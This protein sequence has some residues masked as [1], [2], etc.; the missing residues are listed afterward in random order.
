VLLII[1]LVSGASLGQL[2]NPNPDFIKDNDNLT[3]AAD[4]TKENQGLLGFAGS[5]E[6]H[7]G[8]ITHLSTGPADWKHVKF[9]RGS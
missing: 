2:L 8:V 1:L 6:V 4:V 5:V 3:L 7:V 9:T